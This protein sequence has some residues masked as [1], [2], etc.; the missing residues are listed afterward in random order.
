MKQVR[1]SQGLYAPFKF[2]MERKFAQKVFFS[3][4]IFRHVP[5]GYFDELNY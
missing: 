5:R 3:N 1:S 4:F 2:E